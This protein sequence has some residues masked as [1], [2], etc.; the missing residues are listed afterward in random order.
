MQVDAEV[1]KA[2]LT[3]AWP[4]LTAV[5][6]VLIL[7]SIRKVIESRA[8]T[9]KFAGIEITAQEASDQIKTQIQDLRDQ[10]IALKKLHGEAREPT[11]EALTPERSRAAADA[12][13]APA[14]ILWVDDKPGNNA[15]EIAQLEGL[16]Y[17]VMTAPSTGDAMT[18]LGRERIGLI[19]SD[20]GRRE[21][22]RYAPQAGI[23]LLEAV[24]GAPYRQPFIMYSS[25]RY[26][27]RNDAEVKAK[28]GVGATASPTQL[29]E[30]IE[31]RL[32]IRNGG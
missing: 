27:E 4:L 24:R 28:G 14:T 25:T 7:P 23:S 30:W 6:L 31:A 17:K 8:F 2:I 15:L 19:I 3:L 21:D 29:R 13:E 9:V 18:I 10:I 22:G 11:P 5:I 32:P 26:A 16:G 1:L 12:V 20:M